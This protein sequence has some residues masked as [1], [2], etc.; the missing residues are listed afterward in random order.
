MYLTAWLNSSVPVATAAWLHDCMAAWLLPPMLQLLNPLVHALFAAQDFINFQL[1]G[2]MVG[3]LNNASV[4]WHYSTDMGWP[5][6]LLEKLGL[7]E[8]QQKWPQELVAPG[9]HSRFPPCPALS[10]CTMQVLRNMPI[11]SALHCPL[12]HFAALHC[13]PLCF[14]AL[15]LP[16]L[17]FAHLLHPCSCLPTSPPPPST[18]P[19][20]CRWFPGRAHSSGGGTPGAPRG[21]GGGAGRRRCLHRNGGAGRAAAGADGAAHGVKPPPPGHDGEAVS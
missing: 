20:A 8:L 1:T 18:E 16:L 5:S 6:S 3:S 4:R 14:A 15:P 7:A 2:R 9:E 13:P 11:A 10:V 21:H 19:P 12:L 17:H